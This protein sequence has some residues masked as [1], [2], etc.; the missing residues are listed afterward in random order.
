LIGKKAA[1][2][3]GT[4]PEGKQHSLYEI[5]APYTALFFYYAECDHCIEETPRLVEFYRQWKEQGVEVFA[6]ALGTEAAEWKEFVKTQQMNWV[7]VNDMEE[8]LEIYQHYSIPGTPDIYLLDA[9]KTIIGKH[10]ITRDLPGL[11][12]QHKE[13]VSIIE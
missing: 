8:N 3:E 12:M 6:V 13:A 10:L 11:I 1:N 7:N 2:I 4:D 9:D 5:D